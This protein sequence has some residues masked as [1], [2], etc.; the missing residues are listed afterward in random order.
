MRRK[1]RAYQSPMWNR[2]VTQPIDDRDGMDGEGEGTS[3]EE[4]NGGREWLSAAAM[5][6][7]GGAPVGL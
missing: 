2:L 3:G 1:V 7:D 4:E 6:I 5:T